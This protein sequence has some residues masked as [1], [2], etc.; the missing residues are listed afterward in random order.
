MAVPKR[1]TLAF[2]L[3]LTVFLLLIA[4]S[5]R[6][7][8]ATAAQNVRGIHTLADSRSATDAQ[9]TWARSLVGANGHVTQPF[10]GLDSGTQGPSPEA[11]YFVEQAYARDLDPILVLEGHFAGRTGCNASG[12]EGWLKPTPD[13]PGSPDASY[14]AVA[15][16]YR[17]FVVGLPRVDGRTLYVQ[18]GN[19][20]N[21]HEQ[22]GGAASPAEYAHFFADVSAAIRSIGDGRITILNAALAP[23]GDVDNLR[24]IAEAIRAE[25]RFTSAFDH[26]ASHPY[27]R[28]QPP[29]HN[30][31]DGTALPG[32]RNTVDAYLL[33]L[34]ALAEHGLD[35][36]GLQVVLTETG[37][38]LG[39]TTYPEYPRISEELRADYIQRA[40]EEYWSRWPE[41]RAVTPFA[42]AGWHG[43]WA[44]FDW[45]RPSSTT[46]GHGFPTQPHLQYAR[47]TPGTGIVLGTVLDDG[48]FPL[49][50]ARVSSHPDAHQAV[51]LPDGTFVMLT[52][53]GVYAVTAEKPGYASATVGDVVVTRGQ[54]A[55]LELALPAR[56]PTAVQN[57]DFEAGDL[58]GWTR[59]GAVDGV[60][61]GPWY[62]DVAAREG[63][64]FLGTAVNCGAKDGGV[65][66]SIAAQ[67]GSVVTVRAWT[68]TLEEGS[69][70][71][72]NRVGVDPSGGTE[73]TADLVVWSAWVETGGQWEQVAVSA[74]TVADRVTIFLEHDQDPA[75]PWNI[76]AFDAVE[77]ASPP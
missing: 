11:E 59:W 34:A 5:S 10:F 69:A 68:L 51:T 46:S 66:Q 4:P 16:G 22:W 6:G 1:V 7:Q 57:G 64:G 65:Q 75:N 8:V 60:Q 58:A 61:A 71:I 39:D 37:Y 35:S 49:K 45:V 18:V 43:S 23:E 40:I 76:S 29:E 33:E 27:P 56:L 13:S 36:A 25:P 31:H 38:Q 53:P 54:A 48:G 32:S 21:L 9:L 50:D 24:F 26:W 55:R 44:E 28:N 67:P 63:A 15:E 62:A 74:Q 73:P 72:R 12:F 77:L 20:P 42:L 30:L 19:E 70:G 52:H 3:Y 47:L 41:V 2:L 17:R 14:T